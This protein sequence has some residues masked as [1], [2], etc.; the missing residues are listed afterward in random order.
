MTS[1]IETRRLC[2]P[3]ELLVAATVLYMSV[4][5]DGFI[6]GPNVGPDNGLGDGGERLH[7]WLL[8]GDGVGDDLR[9]ALRKGGVNGEVIDEFMSTGAVVAGRGT[10]Q[11]AGRWGG[12]HHDRVRVY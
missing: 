10:F 2:Q 11:P 12:D 9:D 8:T 4:S 7:D 5:L 1:L 6:A 3:F